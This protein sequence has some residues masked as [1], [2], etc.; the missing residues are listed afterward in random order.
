M[1]S[2]T[3]RRI[4]FLTGMH[5]SGTSF[6]AKR[7][8]DQ[9]TFPGPHLPANED[10]PEGYWEARSVVAINNDILASA[11]LDWRSI[12]PWRPGELANLVLK[13]KAQA[14]S[15]LA[16]MAD[17]TEGD[18]AV[19]DPRLCRTLP[20]W[21][22]ALRDI[23]A[24][25]VI[26]ATIR[27]S[28]AVSRSLY[29]R[30]RDNRFRPAAI[31]QPGQSVLLWLRYMTDLEKLSRS[32]PR[33]FFT[34]DQLRNL[35]LA[36]ITGPTSENRSA[37]SSAGASEADMSWQQISE[38]VETLLRSSDESSV[39]TRLDEIAQRLDS[40]LTPEREAAGGTDM[41]DEKDPLQIARIYS[42]RAG[43]RLSSGQVVG[44]ISGEPESRGHIYRIENRIYSLIG[45]D[46]STFRADPR[47]HSP[48]DIVSVCDLVVVFRKQM[49]AWLD[50]VCNAAA[51][52]G[53]P[54][55]FDI[56]DL[57]FR[58]E[59]M[60]PDTFRYLEGKPR[61]FVRDW[62]ERAHR[63]ALAAG[64]ANM[65]WVTTEP[66]ADQME[67]LNSSVHVLR[68]GLVDDP[69]KGAK[70]PGGRSEV[71]IGYASGTPTHDRDFPVAAVAIARTL[72]AYPQARL[73]IVGELSEVSLKALLPVADQVRRRPIV[74][75]YSLAGELS[76]FDINIAPLETGN[77]FCEC[78]SE[79]KFFEPAML[80]IPTIAS[81]TRPF[82]S[83][84]TSGED[85]FICEHESEWQGALETLVADAAVRRQM[86]ASAR[87]RSMI[88]FGPERQ[89]ADLMELLSELLPGFRSRPKMA[90]PQPVGADAQ[91]G[92]SLVEVMVGLAITAAIS[93]LIFSSLLSQVRQA[94]IVRSS[95][96]SAFVDIA[97]QRL[98]ETVISQTLP[99]WADETEGRFGG[100]GDVISGTSAFSLFGGPARLESY[101]LS[102]VPEGSE[103]TLKLVTEEGAWD[104]ATLEAGS[105]FQYLGGGGAWH[106]T[107]PVA[108]G[109]GRTVAELERYFANQGLPRMIGIWNDDAAKFV[110]YQIALE[111]T[112]IL[113]TRARDLAEVAP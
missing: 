88:S 6:L 46:I 102:L 48:E 27:P 80:S 30:R 47:A 97:A 19:K 29:R 10:N 58:P 34:F 63:Y 44:F 81:A 18:F 15:I 85:G 70:S 83:A 50:A 113:P 99:S 49:D 38:E 43:A 13:F 22:E 111:N 39:Q 69:M 110:G 78:K 79:L 104:V 66:L 33:R 20:V 54:I 17:Q 92:F 71:V 41:L 74:D 40:S 112:D 26:L 87:S 53:V 64:A 51:R 52:Q 94:D 73:E 76:R 82:R 36:D 98:T 60:T 62:Q 91:S 103:L 5:R 61:D 25:P 101:T 59:L 8:V 106:D 95:T 35:T 42:A 11:G 109:P 90:S 89:K 14:A 16:E 67:M 21:L 65:C 105:R 93:V 24:K 7:L 4:F 96:Q 12:R 28:D 75:Y 86:G 32:S 1:I 45:E 9:L 37:Y 72:A 55:V 107:W 108:E 56:D 31:D 84:M 68:N 57:I 77:L 3:P 2:G 100:D 23:G